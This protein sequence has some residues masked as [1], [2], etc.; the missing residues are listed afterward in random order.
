MGNLGFLYTSLNGRIGRQQFWLGL[1][2]LIVISLLLS[3]LILPLIGVRMM[4]DPAVFA[5]PTAADSAAISRTIIDALNASAWASLIMFVVFAW[6]SLALLVKRRHDRNA[7]GV[8][9]YV[10]YALVLLSVLLPVF[11]LG[12]TLIEV[13]GVTVPAPTMI[14]SA[15]GL[16]T[17]VFGIYLLVV[18]GFLKGT[19]GPNQYGPDPLGGGG[20]APA[21]A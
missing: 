13:G 1:V 3:F 18:A 2:I 7:N 4:V 10:F 11:G 12:Y 17:G 5:D 15:L 16:V 20:A 19:T 9:V 21:T 8:D 14:T 6:P